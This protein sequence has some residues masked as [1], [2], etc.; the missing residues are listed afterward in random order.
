MTRTTREPLGAPQDVPNRNQLLIYQAPG[1]RKRPAECAE[2][3][4]LPHSAKSKEQGVSDI[5]K[6]FKNEALE[7]LRGTAASNNS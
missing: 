2:R 7:T 1:A 3:L 6:I 4:N 5:P